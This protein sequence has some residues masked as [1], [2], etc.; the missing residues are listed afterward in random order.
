MPTVLPIFVYGSLLSGFENHRLFVKPYPHETVPA[1]ISG[2]LYH[3]PDR[4]YPAVVPAPS[5]EEAWVYGELLYFSPEVYPQAL[6][7][8]DFLETYHG[9]GDERNEYERKIITAWRFDTEEQV[10]A[11]GYLMEKA[12]QRAVAEQGI[13]LTAGNW[14]Q[15]MRQNHTS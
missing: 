8:L 5:G 15:F 14:R 1:R 12:G 4:G 10:E 11:Y 6:A 7:G 3:L 2:Y 9:A 13:R